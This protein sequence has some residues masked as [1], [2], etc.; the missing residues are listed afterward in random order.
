MVPGQR[1]LQR[2]MHRASGEAERDPLRM[3]DRA[4][5]GQ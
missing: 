3:S 2:R 4:A 5:G 1:D